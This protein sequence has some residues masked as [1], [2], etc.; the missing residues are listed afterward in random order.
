M[1]NTR[2]EEAYKNE[3]NQKIV[4]TGSRISNTPASI[5]NNQVAGVHEGD[6]IKLA[7]DFFELGFT[8]K[9][10]IICHLY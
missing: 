5:T 4:I 6:F 10:L 7:G 3:D 1:R 8:P 2:P 9:S